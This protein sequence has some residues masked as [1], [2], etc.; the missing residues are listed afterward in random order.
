MLFNTHGRCNKCHAPSEQQLDPTFFIDYDFHNIGIGMI[1]HHVV[2]LACKAE[3]IINS[4]ST[5][6]V[7]NAAIESDMSVLG[8]FLITKKEPD[9]AAFKTPGLRN[10]LITAPYFHD[11]S[12][13]TL[14]DVMDHYNKG[15][16][17][18]NPYLDEDIQPLALTEAEIDDMVAFL[19]SLTS[20]DYHDIGVK[21]LARQRALS[22][23]QSA[24]ARHRAGFR[25]E[26]STAEG[27][28][29]L[30]VDCLGRVRETPWIADERRV[31][32]RT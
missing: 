15:N 4:G 19:A 31:A 26:A 20:A 13:E 9:I 32:M 14:W 1:R 27:V 6:A 18:E 11:G 8:R 30:S 25:S 22:R 5:F 29:G 3:Q 23:N 7:D 28:A 24:A 2:P 16:G 17:L 10:V 21:E 12:Q